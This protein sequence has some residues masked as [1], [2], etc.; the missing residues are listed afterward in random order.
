MFYSATLW[1][2]CL[3]SNLQCHVENLCNPF[4][5]PLVYY[6]EKKL[7]LL[8]FRKNGFLVRADM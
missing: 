4:T 7:V 2:T 3:L 6:Y 5:F 1:C 8:I